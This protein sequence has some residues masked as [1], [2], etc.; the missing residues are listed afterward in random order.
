M[1]RYCL[2]G[3]TV[4]TASRMESNGEA[5][6]IHISEQLQEFLVKTDEY[7]IEDRGLVKMKGKGE[8][9]T[10]WLLGHKDPEGKNRRE[11]SCN[12]AIAVPQHVWH[13]GS[14][15]GSMVTFRNI[16]M[17]SSHSHA[18]LTS[19]HLLRLQQSELNHMSNIS[20]SGR[21]SPRA[22]KKKMRRVKTAAL[23][24]KEESMESC[25]A[26][27]RENV[28][29]N[30]NHKRHP[31]APC[32]PFRSGAVAQ[33]NG[34]VTECNAAVNEC[35][36]VP[37]LV[38][39]SEGHMMLN[40]RDEDLMQRMGGRTPPASDVLLP[41]SSPAK[42]K[43]SPPAAVTRPTPILRRHEI[44]FKKWISLNEIPSDAESRISH[45][46]SAGLL[47]PEPEQ[48]IQLEKGQRETE[49]TIGPRITCPCE[50]SGRVP[51]SFTKWISGLV[52]RKISS[53]SNLYG[54]PDLNQH[55]LPLPTQTNADT[56]IVETN[57]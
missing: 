3:D 51:L 8:V 5:L 46:S 37:A 1:P 10:F 54:S 22:A 35:R 18:N 45:S 4:N 28:Q 2:F 23:S 26:G 53:D 31:H 38:R 19:L 25:M 36:W 6:K 34:A 13:S 16:P 30:N 17:P 44:G 55:L 49:F 52:L 15:R 33:T 32:L 27:S 12:M 14:R 21:S 43:V 7:A 50:D 29:H 39:G 11:D 47:V 24:Q 40:E 41:D 57:V 9:R 56:V 20:L 48:V 42:R